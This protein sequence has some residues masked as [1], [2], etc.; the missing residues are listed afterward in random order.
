LIDSA[1]NNHHRFV[2]GQFEPGFAMP[3]YK[4]SEWVATNGYQ[5]RAWKELV[6]LWSVYNR[7]LLFLMERVPKDRLANVCKIGDDDPVTLEFLMVDYVRH[8]KHHV[9]QILAG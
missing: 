8:L 1:A 2:R 7:H 9:D 3:S 5:D 4:Q 6:E